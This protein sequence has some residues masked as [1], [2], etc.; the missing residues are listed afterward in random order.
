MDLCER[1][2]ALLDRNCGSG[3]S[4]IA[5]TGLFSGRCLHPSGLRTAAE[6]PRGLQ[7]EHALVRCFENRNEPLTRLRHVGQHFLTTLKSNG[8]RPLLDDT[9]GQDQGVTSYSTSATL[10]SPAYTNTT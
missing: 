4:W 7:V 8:P 10:C 1:A 9:A 5:A 6:R 3:E 2:I